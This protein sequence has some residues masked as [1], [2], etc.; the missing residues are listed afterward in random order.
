VTGIRHIAPAATTDRLFLTAE[1]EHRVR[2]W[3]FADHSLTAELDTVLDFGGQRLALCGAATPIVVAG[4][5]ERH[6]ICGYAPDGT[7]LWQRKDLRQP[8]HI[9]PA[10]GGA[11]VV[12]CFDQRPLHVLDAVSGET[13]ATVRAVRR[14][15]DSPFAEV[16]LGEVYGHAS[17][18]AQTTGRFAGGRLSMASPASRPQPHLARSR[19]ATS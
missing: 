4:A 15:Y 6:G 17:S 10:A 19:W 13:R 16:G 1:F 2:L 12:A 14:Y 8:Q 7:R 9:S 3:S 18:L 5:W 11:L